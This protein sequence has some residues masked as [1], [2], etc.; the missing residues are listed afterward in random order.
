MPITAACVYMCVQGKQQEEEEGRRR[1]PRPR[2]SVPAFGGWDQQGG[3]GG[4][5]HAQAPPDY[6][7]DFTNVRAARMRRRTRALSWSSF[8][9]DAAAA[10]VE[11]ASSSPGEDE[12]QHGHHRRWSSSAAASDGDDDHDRRRRRRSRRGADDDDDRLPIQPRRAAPKGRGNFKG[13]LFG[14]V[15]GLW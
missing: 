4:A 14:C 5:Q 3:A 12:K 8:V 7:L 9:G 1:P 15:G 10:A 11:E 2:A 13:Y 6:S